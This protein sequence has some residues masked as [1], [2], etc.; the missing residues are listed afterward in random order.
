[1]PRVSTGGSHA[2]AWARTYE[3]AA[4][5]VRGFEIG[6]LTLYVARR[7]REWE[8]GA[9]LGADPHAAG[10]EIGR[11]EREVDFA[12]CAWR[13]RYPAPSHVD[14][15]TLS[16]AA[17]DRPVIARPES[18]LLVPANATTVVYLGSPV[19]VRVR[20]GDAEVG[21]IPAWRPSDTWFGPSTT[22]GELCYAS[23]TM[24]RLS[25]DELPFSPVRAITETTIVNEMDVPV[26]VDRIGLPLPA[27]S[28]FR[29]SDGRMWTES[30]AV[31]LEEAG[32]APTRIG[33]TP[34]QI[35]GQCTRLAS[36]RRPPESGGLVRAFSALIDMSRGHSWSG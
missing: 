2:E 1:M 16:A 35:A 30:V 9:L 28:V 15:I 31:S 23:R 29:S 6:P 36:P 11:P 10:L 22:E 20:V 17:A 19:W 27:M 21:E 33:K 26:S 18:S 5:E 12:T 7:S 34:A 25:L 4:G 3:I 8:I 24:A 32:T 14:A 13:F